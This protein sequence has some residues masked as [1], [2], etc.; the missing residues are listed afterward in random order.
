MI[1]IITVIPYV[2]AMSYASCSLL[3]FPP[4]RAFFTDADGKRIYMIY[5]YIITVIPYMYVH[6]MSYASCSLLFFPPAR[7]FFTDERRNAPATIEAP[8]MPSLCPT[9]LAMMDTSDLAAATMP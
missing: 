1:Y 8:T 3:F 2:Y 9:F 5:R 4:A 7:A 6:A